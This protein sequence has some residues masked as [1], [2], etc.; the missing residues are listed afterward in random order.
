MSLSHT[1][2]AD[3]LPRESQIRLL[4]AIGDCDGEWWGNGR[5]EFSTMEDAVRAAGWAA[6]LCVEPPPRLICAA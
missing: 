5:A 4:I 6:R 1:P 2:Y 3:T